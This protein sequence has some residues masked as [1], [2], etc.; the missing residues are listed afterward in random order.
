MMAAVTAGSQRNGI[1]G[2]CACPSERGKTPSGDNMRTFIRHPSD[3]PI[4]IHP[5]D[6]SSHK[7]EYLNNIS[8]GGLSFR[9][10]IPLREGAAIRIKIP[11]VKPAFEARGKVVWCRKEN[12]HFDVGIEFIETGDAFK[13]RMV[14]QICRIENY[15]KEIYEKEGRQLSGKEAAMEWISKYAGKFEAETEVVEK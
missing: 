1:A 14:E 4:E 11:H 12:E 15:K 2:L 8:P 10:Q 5:E 3:I 13:A 6:L 9:S 7:E